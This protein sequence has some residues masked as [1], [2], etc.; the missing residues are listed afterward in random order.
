V[1]ERE[2]GFYS[3]QS[4]VEKAWAHFYLSPLRP[5]EQFLFAW[6]FGPWPLLM[7]LLPS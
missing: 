7:P 6:T 1:E 3:Q 5:A 2:K 4:P